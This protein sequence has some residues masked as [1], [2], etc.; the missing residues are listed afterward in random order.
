MND[1]REQYLWITF[2]N[3]TEVNPVNFC[4][5]GSNV[6]MGLG[7][8]EK[9]GTGELETN[10]YCSSNC[11]ENAWVTKRYAFNPLM[12]HH[13]KLMAAEERYYLWVDGELQIDYPLPDRYKK[14]Y[15]GIGTGYTGTE[16]RNIT[17]NSVTKAPVNCVYFTDSEKEGRR[18]SIP[19]FYEEIGNTYRRVFN[20]SGTF[21]S[22]IPFMF[23]EEK[24]DCFVLEFDLLFADS[25]NKSEPASKQKEDPFRTY[26]CAP[27]PQ[28][29][30]VDWH[31]FPD[32]VETVLHDDSIELRMKKPDWDQGVLSTLFISCPCTGGIRISS[33]AP[34]RDAQAYVGDT[35]IFEPEYS[36]PID[37]EH[38]HGELVGGDGTGVRILCEDAYWRVELY[39]AKKNLIHTIHKWNL[40]YSDDRFVTR[41]YSLELPLSSEEVIF[42]TGERYNHFNQ[43]GCRMCFWN[44]DMCYHG[45]SSLE[46]HEL[47]R[48]Y[49]NVPVVNSNRGV[50]YFFNTTCYGEGD[51]GYSDKTRLKLTFDDSRVDFYVWTGTPVENLVKYTDLTGKPVLPPK[52]AFRYQAGGSNDFWGLGQ[53]KGTEYPREITRTMIEKFDEMGTLPSAIY[54]EGGGADDI[55]C[56]N[57]CNKKNIK[58]LQWNCGDFSPEFMHANYPDKDYSELPMV[59]NIFHPEQVH[60]FGD[61]THKDALATLK[62]IHEERIH[63]GLRGGMVDFTE[64]VPIDTIFDNGL[65]GNRMHNFWVWWYAKTYHDLYM[66]MTDGDYLCYMRGACAGSQKWN[67]TW[68]GDQMNSFDGLKQQ[69]V[70]G[71]SL[72]ASGF[73]IWGTDMGGISEKP[74]DQVYIRAYQFCTFMP[75]MRT[76]G[77]ATKLPWDY[78]KKVQEVF[79]QFYWLRENLL[80]MIYSYAIYSHKTGIP[81]TQA[82][83]LAF[84]E[85]KESAGNEEQYMFCENILFASVFQENAT[86][87]KVYFPKGRWYS[88]FQNEIIDGK[89]E[90]E[91]PAPIEYSPAYVRDGA[92]IPLVLGASMELMEAMPDNRKK[93]ILIAPPVESRDNFAFVDEKTRIEMVSQSLGGDAFTIKITSGSGWKRAVILGEALE[94]KVNSEKLKRYEDVCSFE[95]GYVV[96]NG[97]TYVKVYEGE[98]N[99]IWVAM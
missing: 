40:S 47:W 52:W 57:L 24:M 11:V 60:Y 46:T 29:L 99:T 33:E 23:F 92:V 4:R 73:S 80:D 84:P 69:I 1:R 98:I 89:G 41:Q 50:T 16:I 58:V 54:M 62:R 14:G 51:F 44:T 35:A 36:L 17:I 27:Y 21:L 6:M 25:I 13:M 70:G 34:K 55:I 7:Y 39:D 9:P 76:G 67:C 56:Y 82:M 86:T 49:K 31:P 81:M 77:A 20:G 79:T 90:K 28:Q 59:K 83:A 65:M 2:G 43:H 12:E 37:K 45:Y 48:S 93:G 87:K 72:S 75:I 3:E 96:K 94:V 26:C 85:C 42:G 74:S 91:V 88:L 38:F 10:D 8:H 22:N 32:V 64:L 19:E 61:F 66:D 63:W 95:E 30:H 15:L 5:E 78:G 53:G 71:L 68:T 18:M 97:R